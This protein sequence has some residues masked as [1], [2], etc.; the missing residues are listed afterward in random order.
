MGGPEGKKKK[1]TE[2]LSV[3]SKAMERMKKDLEGTKVDI[4]DGQTQSE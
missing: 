2:I 3:C 1:E 4:E